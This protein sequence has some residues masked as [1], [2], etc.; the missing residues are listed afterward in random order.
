MNTN[1]RP[2]FFANNSLPTTV[3]LRPGLTT[4][5]DLAVETG[6]GSIEIEFLGVG[7]PGGQLSL[8]PHALDVR[9]GRPV[10]LFLYGRGI[11][12]FI[13]GDNIWILGPGV[14]PRP[15]TVTR[16]AAATANGIV[17]VRVTVDV[18]S[19]K[20]LDLATLAVQRG[21]DMSLF[22]G[23]LVVRPSAGGPS[24]SGAANAA[25]GSTQSFAPDS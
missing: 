10:D 15:E 20:T 24:I 14:T 2:A 12:E 3:T 7:A 19:R 4:N 13:A 8:S 9:A 11:D 25:S 21:S 22:T 6:R 16:D 5:V 23:A 17:P 1:F 18:A